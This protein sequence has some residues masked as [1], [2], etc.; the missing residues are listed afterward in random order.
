MAIIPPAS[1]CELRLGCATDSLWPQL[2]FGPCLTPAFGEWL[3]VNYRSNG[4]SM[5]GKKR[6]KYSKVASKKA[7][8]KESSSIVIKAKWG[9]ACG[10]QEE[11]KKRRIQS[12]VC[13]LGK[14]ECHGEPPALLAQWDP[15]LSVYHEQPKGRVAAWSAKL[16]TVLL[17]SPVSGGEHPGYVTDT[18]TARQHERGDHW[19]YSKF[20]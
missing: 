5:G 13:E 10:R 8:L 16:L 20:L 11:R 19:E 15:E 9:D 7:R 4:F 3:E 2:T 18:V 17:A 1:S 6:H 12:S 14:G